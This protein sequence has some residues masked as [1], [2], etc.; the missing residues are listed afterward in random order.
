MSTMTRRLAVMTIAG[1]IGLRM[2][3]AQEDLCR[4]VLKY[5]VFQDIN[6]EKKNIDF[7]VFQSHYCEASANNS[8]RSTSLDLDLLVPEADAAI[9]AKWKEMSQEEKRKAFCSNQLSKTFTDNSLRFVWKRA[10]EKLLDAWLS[11]M[12]RS[13]GQVS[14]SYR[15][16]DDGWEVLLTAVD[17]IEGSHKIVFNGN[18]LRD[19]LVLLPMDALRNCKP[20]AFPDGRER[21]QIVCRR[22]KLDQSITADLL[23]VVGHPSEFVVIPAVENKS[24]HK[25]TVPSDIYV[26]PD[27]V[28][29]SNAYREDRFGKMTSLGG[30]TSEHG[31]YIHAPNGGTATFWVSMPVGRRP[32]WFRATLVYFTNRSCT[33]NPGNMGHGRIHITYGYRTNDTQQPYWQD[34]YETVWAGP[35]PSNNPDRP[36]EIDLRKIPQGAQ[37]NLSITVTTEGAGN[38]CVHSGL[39]DPRFSYHQ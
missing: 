16:S 22:A 37:P 10:D 32:V 25:V 13:S 39:L 5:G 15:I 28:K 35:N 19:Q 23:P 29:E 21:T 30:A 7:R 38:A 20:R 34:V 18:K 27:L 2:L 26:T 33:G 24:Q 31:M 11:C 36:I 4:D 8:R 1:C 9:S 3:P 12:E 17:K 14:F 6:Y